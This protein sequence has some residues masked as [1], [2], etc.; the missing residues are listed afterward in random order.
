MIN[1]LVMIA[2]TTAIPNVAHSE[3]ILVPLAPVALRCR[4]LRTTTAFK[5]SPT[6]RDLRRYS[7]PLATSVRTTVLCTCSQQ[8]RPKLCFHET[9]RVDDCV[10]GV[11]S[12]RIHVGFTRDSSQ[13]ARSRGVEAEDAP[14]RLRRGRRG[15]GP[16]QTLSTHSQRSDGRCRVESTR[17]LFKVN[18]C[19]N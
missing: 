19:G 5:G 1:D 7:T 3:C 9:G 2:A 4:I 12:S 17:S 10:S 18:G 11:S 13:V 6:A 15:T 8:V 14:T 16:R